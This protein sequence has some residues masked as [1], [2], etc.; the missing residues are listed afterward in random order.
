MLFVVLGV[1][2]CKAHNRNRGKVIAI[3]INRN[4]L[5]ALLVCLDFLSA[6]HSDG[7]Y[8]WQV[9]VFDHDQDA[10]LCELD[11][12]AADAMAEA[13]SQ[14]PQACVQVRLAPACSSCISPS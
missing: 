6:R 1:F 12:L 13:V 9:I 5:P 3:F 10:R 14:G 11:E 2:F 7:S 8:G 4:V